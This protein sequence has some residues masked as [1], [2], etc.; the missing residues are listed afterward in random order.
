MGGTCVSYPMLI[1]G[2]AVLLQLI[3][4]P[5][6]FFLGIRMTAEEE[7]TNGMLRASAKPVR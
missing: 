2:K 7:P 5:R 1:H 4:C 3:H 6:S